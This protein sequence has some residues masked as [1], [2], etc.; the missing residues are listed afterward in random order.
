MYDHQF[1]LFLFL[2]LAVLSILYSFF[3]QLCCPS[4][5]CSTNRIHIELTET[6]GHSPHL[7]MHHAGNSGSFDP[8]EMLNT[9]SGLMLI[10]LW[11]SLLKKAQ[12]KGCMNFSNYKCTFLMADMLICQ[13]QLHLCLKAI[14]HFGL[15]GRTLLFCML[16]TG[17]PK[18]KW[19]IITVMSGTCYFAT[20]IIDNAKVFIIST[21]ISFQNS[22]FIVLL[23]NL[24]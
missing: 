20:M 18:L 9:T 16:I 15:P 6:F 24:L 2:Y 22:S 5:F 23:F 12:L 3:V 8:L 10:G 17:T 14:Y 4:H 1:F 19:A 13:T 7:L 11:I 21:V